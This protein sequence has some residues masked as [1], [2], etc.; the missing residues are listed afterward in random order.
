MSLIHIRGLTCQEEDSVHGKIEQEHVILRGVSENYP[1]ATYLLTVTR[2][3]IP[4]DSIA[5]VTTAESPFWIKG[6]RLRH[7]TAY[8]Q[9]NE[10]TSLTGW[11]MHSVSVGSEKK[12]VKITSPMGFRDTVS[13]LGNVINLGEKMSDTIFTRLCFIEIMEAAKKSMTL[14]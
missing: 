13:H 5:S 6:C 9:D 12:R 3:K 11:L 8:L 2:V 1:Y 7:K 14:Y 10:L 4:L